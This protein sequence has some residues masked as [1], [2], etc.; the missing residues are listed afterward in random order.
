MSI[1]Q[2]G[3][4]RITDEEFGMFTCGECKSCLL[5]EDMTLMILSEFTDFYPQEYVK[6]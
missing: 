6:L 5:P 3:Q 2:C 1:I 4:R